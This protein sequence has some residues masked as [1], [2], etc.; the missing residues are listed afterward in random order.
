MTVEECK[1]AVR[2]SS[3]EM[4]STAELSFKLAFCVKASPRLDIVE[5]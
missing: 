4:P 2:M 5:Q 3:S 1:T